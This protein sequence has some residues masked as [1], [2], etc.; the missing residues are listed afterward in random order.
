MIE[1]LVID[2]VLI[3]I[4]FETLVFGNQE[5]G[6]D[7]VN[8]RVDNLGESVDKPSVDKENTETLPST[9]S[10]SILPIIGTSLL[11]LSSVLYVVK[12]KDKA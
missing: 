2:K 8:Q 5:E 9:G 12:K 3:L 6:F 7:I 10:V 4:D 1:T 11:G